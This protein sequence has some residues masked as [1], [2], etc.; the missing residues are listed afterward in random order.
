MKMR[1]QQLKIAFV[2][3]FLQ[4]VEANA[5]TQPIA[6]IE[7]VKKLALLK[8]TTDECLVSSDFKKSSDDFQRKVVN[9]SNKIDYMTNDLHEMKQ[10]KLLYIAYNF[11]LEKYK[12]SNDFRKNLLNRSGNYCDSKFVTEV[13][14]NVKRIELSVVPYIARSQKK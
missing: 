8:A 2:L 12:K 5:Q 9:I 13:E 11:T 7:H 3:C 4:I 10:N 1:F 14:S 6:I